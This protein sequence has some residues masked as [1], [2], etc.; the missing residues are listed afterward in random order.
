M[1]ELQKLYVAT[2]TRRTSA[3]ELEAVI[4]MIISQH[5]LE[6]LSVMAPNIEDA[7][8]SLFM[9]PS[10]A[11]SPRSVPLKSGVPGRG[12]IYPFVLM[13]G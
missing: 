1:R 10:W 2:R 4:K 5:Q 9:A 11:T 13:S 6:T 7:M 12:I 8:A 3:L